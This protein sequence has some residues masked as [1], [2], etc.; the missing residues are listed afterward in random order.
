M[1]C[2]KCGYQSFNNLTACK[3]C[4]RDLAEVQAKLNLGN[5]VIVPLPV[6]PPTEPPPAVTEIPVASAP[7]AVAVKEQNTPEDEH[8]LEDFFQSIDSLD[9]VPSDPP[10]DRQPAANTKERSTAKRQHSTEGPQWSQE[11]PQGDFPFDELD[12]DLDA[13]QLSRAAEPTAD[14]ASPFDDVDSFEINWQSLMEEEVIAEAEPVTESEPA[15]EGQSTKEEWDLEELPTTTKPV[16]EQSEIVPSAKIIEPE[17][18]PEPI[19]TEGPTAPPITEQL[20]DDEDWPLPELPSDLHV[21]KNFALEEPCEPKTPAAEA[22]TDSAV[23]SEQPVEVQEELPLAAREIETPF[24][25]ANIAAI[26]LPDA[27][28]DPIASGAQLLTRRAKAYLADF[29]LLTVIFAI[30]VCAGEVARSPAP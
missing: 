8:G 4:G 21:E 9:Q 28:Q 10:L 19:E 13:L 18:E 15:S 23:P 12:S 25:Q 20:T 7:A 6:Q 11:S 17:P 30:F 14:S 22:P 2:P 3:K 29:G 1:K 27:E 24:K 16:T 26:F 5:P